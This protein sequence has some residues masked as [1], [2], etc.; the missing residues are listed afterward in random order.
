[1]TSNRNGFADALDQLNT[2]MNIDKEVELDA[3]EEAADFFAAKLRAAVPLGPGVVHLKNEIKVIIKKD[4]A[5]V[6]FGDKAWYW[7]LVD[8]GHR[9]RGGRGRVKGHHFVRKTFDQ[10][11]D[12]VAD[13]MATKIIEKMEG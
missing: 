4:M 12:K 2:L 11:G 5:Q 3:L 8:K 10:Y 9:K 7:H 6:V 1:M 13:I